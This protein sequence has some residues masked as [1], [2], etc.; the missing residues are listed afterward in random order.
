MTTGGVDHHRHAALGI[1][2]LPEFL[3]AAVEW[4]PTGVLIVN[5][6]S[7]ILAA[8]REIERVFGYTSTELT[9]ESVDVL[10]PDASRSAHAGLRDNYLRHPK[11]RI[12]AAAREVFG[13]RKDGSEVP[14]EVRLTPVALGETRFVL[15][16]VIDVS[17]R[18][19]LQRSVRAS[20]DERRQFEALVGDLGAE[21]VNLRPDDIDRTIEEALGRVV[22]TL[23]LDRSA[24]FQLV[25]ESG[26]FV[27]THQWTRPGWPSPS[28]RVPAAEQLPWHLTQIRAGH[29]VSFETLD[30]VPDEIDRASLARL[31][32]RSSIT[33]PIAIE[34]RT[35]GAVSFGVVRDS[36]QWTPEVINRLRVVALIFA[37]VLARRQ[38]DEALRRAVVEGAAMRDRL[39]DENAYL[40]EEL[41]GLTGAP[42][43]VGHSPAFRRVL[44]LIRQ[45]AST[46]STV[47]LLGETG[48]GKAMLANRI[49]EL[50][51]RRER[52]MVRVNCASLSAAW[53]ESELFGAEDGTFAATESRHVGRLQLANGSTVFLDEIADL[54]LDAQAILTRVLRNRHIQPHGSATP[55]TVDV[56]IVAATRKDLTRCIA[57]GTFRDDLYDQLNVVPI[58]LPPLRERPEDIPL[59]VWRFVDEFSEAYGKRIDAIDQESMAAMQRHS[60][61]GNARELRNLVERAMIVPTGRRLRIA[62]PPNER[63]VI[64]RHEALADVEKEHIT[65]VL[66]ACG[67]QID[68][69]AGAAARLGLTARALKMRMAKLGVRR[70]RE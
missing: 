40:R 62:L 8:N 28:P 12:M 47:L 49:H 66:F 10:V 41:K 60:W 13:R 34:G 30:E 37:S 22:R 69:K 61:P 52:A 14:V 35:W 57:E 11:P 54:P 24:L 32:T 50:S 2:A 65:Q 43:I 15:A 1:D 63:G 51:A 59:F 21:F 7:M 33:V 26:D 29:L 42:I 16:S 39:R 19:R 38:G 45:A 58:H 70:P 3:R 48:T 46:D 17:D 9:G 55:M 18:N 44:E 6:D 68:G 56:R 20:R 23:D 27:H 53:I 4:L 67:G 36:R 25:D 64:R 5:A 31:G